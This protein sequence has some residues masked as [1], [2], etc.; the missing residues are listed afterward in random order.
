MLSWPSLIPQPPKNNS[1]LNFEVLNTVLHFQLNP[2]SGSSVITTG[3][4][5]TDRQMDG[6]TDRQV[7]NIYASSPLGGGI[8]TCLLYNLGV[9]LLIPGKDDKPSHPRLPHSHD[10]RFFYTPNIMIPLCNH[11]VS[12]TRQCSTRWHCLIGNCR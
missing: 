9:W 8:I 7:E 12:R 1:G 2:S 5:V 10:E 4:N 3:K 11:N 6:Q